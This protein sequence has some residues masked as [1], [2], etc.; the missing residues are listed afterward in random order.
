MLT[1]LK[2]KL[3]GKNKNRRAN[4]NNG[5]LRSINLLS[6]NNLNLFCWL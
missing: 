4:E 3:V 2:E 5:V 6:I 1:F